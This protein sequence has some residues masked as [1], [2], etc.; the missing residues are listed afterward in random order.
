MVK[1]LEEKWGVLH[2]IATSAD[3]SEGAKIKVIDPKKRWGYF[4]QTGKHSSYISRFK[5]KNELRKISGNISVGVNQQP[6][7]WG[8][9]RKI[10][11]RLS[12]RLIEVRKHYLW[13]IQWKYAF[14]FCMNKSSCSYVFYSL[15]NNVLSQST[16][17]FFNRSL[18][19]SWKL[20]SNIL[21]DTVSIIPKYIMHLL[22]WFELDWSSISLSIHQKPT[23]TSTT[24]YYIIGKEE[25]KE[26]L[27]S[28]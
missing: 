15:L 23:S 21:R 27:S 1:S 4:I 19:F 18:Y 3:Q 5:A 25:R 6:E 10:S 12:V 24:P 13:I 8:C 9:I 7:F 26:F 28:I 22:H 11:V 16:V 14:I 17:L 2:E 20:L